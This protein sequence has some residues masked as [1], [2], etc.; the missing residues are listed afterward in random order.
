M[1][2]FRRTFGRYTGWLIVAF[3]ILAAW[4]TWEQVYGAELRVG[5]GGG[6]TNDNEWIG[7]ELMVNSDRRHWYASVIRVGGDDALPDTW[8]FA[9]GYRV[10][11]RRDKN[12]WPY[13]RLGAG[14]FL[15]EPGHLISDKLAFDMAVGIRFWKIL[16]LEWQ[17]NSTAGRS[18]HNDGNDILM[19]GLVVPFGA[20]KDDRG[21]TP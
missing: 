3:I 10:N 16:E 19:L 12:V 18:D 21:F 15:D 11:W 20:Q 5:L 13:L 7:Q 9:A 4:G 1:R 8:R 17:H 14:Y 6:V 2:Q